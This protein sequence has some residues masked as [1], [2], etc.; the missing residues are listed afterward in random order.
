MKPKLNK[1]QGFFSIHFIF[2][3]SL[4]SVTLLGYTYIFYVQKQKDLFR[5]VCY[6]DLAQIQKQ[7]V[8][9]EKQLFRLNV[10]STFLRTRLKML[11]AEL[12]LAVASQNAHLVAKINLEIQQVISQQKKLDLFQKSIIQQ[13]RIYSKSQLSLLNK[14]ITSANNHENS[15]WKRWVRENKTYSLKKDIIFAVK[16]DAIGGLAPNYELQDNYKRLQELNFNLHLQFSNEQKN[17]NLLPTQQEYSLFCSI[18]FHN[19][20]DLWDLK[21]NQDKL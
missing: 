6:Y 21:I 14:Q 15:I 16:P 5:K 7:L 8:L 3:V 9:F 13:A 4:I 20:G 11:Y 17:Q 1:Q 18:S 2:F 19:Q 10:P 12:A